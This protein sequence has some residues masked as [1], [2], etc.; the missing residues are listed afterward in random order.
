MPSEIENEWL[1]SAEACRILGISDRTL[2]RRI[3]AGDVESKLE[4][5]PRGG[6]RRVVRVTDRAGQSGDARGPS[7]RAT[8]ERET[9][10]VRANADE[11][12]G[13]AGQIERAT[14]GPEVESGN[15]AAQQVERLEKEV[16]FLR[17]LV[18]QH[19]RAE[20]ELRAALRETL[21]AMPRELTT[22]TS[23]TPEAAQNRPQIAATSNTST[24]AQA[25]VGLAAKAKGAASRRGPRAMW[26]L[27]LGIR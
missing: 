13:R 21:K 22:G 2:K 18:E 9:E 12:A 19:Q 1:A 23:A 25:P 3:E 10:S 27:I 5:L 16:E 20:A 14:R 8:N 26:K 7:V 24:D 15:V 6:V 11:R 4:T 17:G